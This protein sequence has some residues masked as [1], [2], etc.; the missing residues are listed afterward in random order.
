MLN[1]DT[2]SEA[3]KRGTRQTLVRVLEATLRLAHPIMP[4]ITEEIWQKVAPLAGAS[5]ETIM[6]Q[7]F[8]QADDS[9][10]DAAATAEMEWVMQFILGIR[11]IKG[12]MNIAPGKP[13]PVLLA[14]TSEA[15]RRNAEAHRAYL[16]FLARV[17]SVEVLAEGETGPESAT[18][19]IGKMKVLI[20][21]AGLID[22]DAELKRL[23]KEMG[24]LEGDIKRT[25]GKLSNASFVDKA[26]EAVVQK[27][28][29]KLEEARA[30]LQNLSEQAEKIRAL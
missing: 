21:L 9:L 15:D 8:P 29:D 11:S 10:V 28:K 23:E 24:K 7:A 14:D 26:P 17:E 20:P 2:A 1:S 30:A 19:L 13:V 12:E 27:E 5:G 25:E 4:Y 6:R 22:K 3:A 16:D 18:A